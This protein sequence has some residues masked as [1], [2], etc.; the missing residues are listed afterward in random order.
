LIRYVWQ[1]NLILLDPNF[2]GYLDLTRKKLH[3]SYPFSVIIL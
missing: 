2:I 1:D 3:F